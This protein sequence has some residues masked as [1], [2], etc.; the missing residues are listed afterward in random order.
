MRNPTN[1]VRLLKN[2]WKEEINFSKKIKIVSVKTILPFFDF[3]S[4]GQPIKCNQC[5]TV[6]VDPSKYHFFG[7]KNLM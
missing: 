2:T 4:Q 6:K 5:R 7:I 3:D 1:H